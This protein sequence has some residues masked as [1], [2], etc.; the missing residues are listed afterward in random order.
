MS[1]NLN[2]YTTLVPKAFK[3]ELSNLNSPETT[4]KMMLLK[5]GYY[6]DANTHSSILDVSSFEIE[7]ENYNAGGKVLENISLTTEQGVTTFAADNI[8]WD[9]STLSFRYL[10]VYDD[11]LS[12]PSNKSLLFYADFG[13][14]IKT[15]NSEFA[16]RWD[17]EGIFN[18]SVILRAEV[19]ID[20]T[21][22]TV[23]E[24]QELTV[25]VVA[26]DYE[27]K[28]V[29]AHFTTTDAFESL[30]YLEQNPEH[31]SYG[32]WFPLE[33]N[34]FGPISGFPMLDTESKFRASFRE[35]GEHKITLSFISV[36]T[37]ETI[38]SHK[39]VL[40]AV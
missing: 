7:G 3:N 17:D 33:G 37:S 19:M 9:N 4:L 24:Q 27:N 1:T 31:P 6:P 29:R 22:F 21:V 32:Q 39:F 34:M 10:V 23:G 25:R 14:T 38:L 5:D 36:E 2:I 40:S 35:E 16:V 30:E 20:A 15:R 8:R 12:D 18:M 13:Q 26:N 11:T 28:L